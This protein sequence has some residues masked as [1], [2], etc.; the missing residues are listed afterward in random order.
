MMEPRTLVRLGLA[1]AFAA[2]LT[3]FAHAERIVVPVGTSPQ[4]IVDLA[5]E[6]DVIVLKRGEHRG[7]IRVARKVTVEGEPGA[8]LVGP[9][10]GSAVTV[11][12]PGAVVR[13]LTIR[14]SGRDSEKMDAGVFVE[15][16]AT[17]AVVEGNRIEGNL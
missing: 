14:G 10:Q 16:T 7:S 4:E 5:A 2:N 8:I 13:N 1:A 17:G 6:G 9:G 15:K 11:S 12:A 3:S